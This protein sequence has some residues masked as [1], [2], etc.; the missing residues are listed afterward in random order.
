VW[1]SACR[2][3]MLDTPWE[4]SQ[5]VKDGLSQEADAKYVEICQGKHPIWHW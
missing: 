5:I 4:T 1:L 2:K 3:G